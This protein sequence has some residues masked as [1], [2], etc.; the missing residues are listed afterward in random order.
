M[1]K[2]IYKPFGP[3][4]GVFEIE[5]K[6]INNINTYV[7]KLI[8][9]EEK[10]SKLDMGSKLAGQVR[11]EFS[12][13]NNYIAKEISPF[14]VPIIKTYV[15]DSV[16]KNVTKINFSECWVV[17][18][19]KHEYNPLHSHSTH[20]SGVL[21]LK[22]PLVVGESKKKN[23]QHG[24]ILFTHVGLNFFSPRNCPFLKYLPGIF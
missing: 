16:G 14:L 20:I 12:L 17:R 2:K 21:Y 10:V 4:I 3:S 13:E 7:E 23:N 19:Y 1:K 22:V 24:Q 5:D 6:I 11:Q 9:S 15:F 18:Q 8:T